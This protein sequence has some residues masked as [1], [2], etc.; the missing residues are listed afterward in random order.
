VTYKY[1]ID[2]FDNEA[3]GGV[4]HLRYIRS[5]VGVAYTMPTDRFGTNPAPPLIEQSFGNLVAGAPSGGIIPITWS[6]RQCVTLQVRTNLSSG[7]WVDLTATDAASA[8]NYPNTG[9]TRFFR[10]K[11]S[12]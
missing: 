11:K 2:G 3:P 10:L 1:G 9:G 5:P 6:G 7:V 4:N 8:T 12:P